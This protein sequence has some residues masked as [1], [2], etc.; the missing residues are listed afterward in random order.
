[1]KQHT[2]ASLVWL[3]CIEWVQ[4]KIIHYHSILQ[5][6]LVYMQG[7]LPFLKTA[8]HVKEK[9]GEAGERRKW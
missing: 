1:M 5:L 3:L 8:C 7:Y 6:A 2:T 9:E 4:C